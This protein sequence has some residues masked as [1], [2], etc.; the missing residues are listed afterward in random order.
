MRALAD[1]APR[2]RVLLLGDG[3]D[4]A[5]LGRVAQELGLSDTVVFAGFLDNPHAVAFRAA[6]FVLPSRWEGYSLALVE[7]LCLGV[8][9]V[10]ADCVSGPR[11]ILE[12]GKY[13][14]LVP[15]DDE[16]AL[17]LPSPSTS[18]NLQ[19]SVRRQRRARSRPCAGSTRQRLR[20]STSSC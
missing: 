3:P 14:R 1:G 7:A 9:A 8:P 4:R 15:V 6:L 19:L 12:D 18:P 13:G 20:R 10:A 2:H 16:E 5:A 11:E 17:A